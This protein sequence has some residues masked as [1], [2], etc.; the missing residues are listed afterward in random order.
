VTVL[1]EALSRAQQRVL[2]LIVNH[3]TPEKPDLPRWFTVEAL[4]KHAG[5]SVQT[6]RGHLAVLMARG[7]V[8]AASQEQASRTDGSHEFGTMYRL[9]LRKEGDNEAD[10]VRGAEMSTVLGYFTRSTTA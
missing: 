4:T 10:F 7:F 5:E 3:F 8:L 9:P 2:D 1:H 6:L